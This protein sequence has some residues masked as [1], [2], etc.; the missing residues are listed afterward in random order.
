[1]AFWPEERERWRERNKKIEPKREQE[2][3]LAGVLACWKRETR[4]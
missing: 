1:M 2:G 3:N 4:K